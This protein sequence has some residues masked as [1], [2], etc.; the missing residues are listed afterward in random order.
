MLSFNREKCVYCKL[1]ENVCS[2]RF[3]QQVRPSVAAIRIGREGKWGLPS[4]RICDL[5]KDLE[6]GPKCVAACP[7]D[8]LG[9]S[10]GGVI[11]WDDEKCTRCEVCV[12]V[13]PNKAVAYDTDS[14][15]IILCDLC[16]GKPLCIEWCPEQVISA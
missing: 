8:A 3:T 12:D 9:V 5:C 14:D 7:E 1:C 10:D 6:E 16:G 2:F 11:A 13:C 4:A 15:R